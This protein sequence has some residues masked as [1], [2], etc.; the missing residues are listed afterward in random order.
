M[1]EEITL[2]GYSV[3]ATVYDRLNDTVDYK[4]WADFIEECFR[5]YSTGREVRSVIDLGCGTGSMTL[6]LARRG[7]DMTALDISEEM[8]TVA[9]NRVRSEKLSDVLFVESDMCS[10]ELYGTVD[11]MVCCLDGINHLTSREELLSCFALVNNYLEDGGVFVFDLNT[12][13][14]FKTDYADRDYILEDDGVMC[15]WRNRLNKKQD[16][17]DFCLTVF[18]EK[19]GVWHRED[20]I[21][22]ERAYGIRAITNALAECGMEVCCVCAD[23]SFAEPDAD[24]KR[25]YITARKIRNI[26]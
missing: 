19:N 4:A 20:G 7:Y 16:K 15:C 13:H 1:S 5:R 12:P 18:R 10:F 11:A 25:W 14:K 9:E 26:R 23:Y 21:E 3:L 17:V 8:L 6:E 2:S 24:C 22:T